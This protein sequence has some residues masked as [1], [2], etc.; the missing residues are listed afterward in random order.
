V[1]FIAPSTLEIPKSDI[2]NIL[3]CKKQ[4]HDVVSK[5][6]P[7]FKVSFLVANGLDVYFSILQNGCCV[8]LIE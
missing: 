1:V 7:S 6:S 4:S 3:S 8:L 2:D 5:I